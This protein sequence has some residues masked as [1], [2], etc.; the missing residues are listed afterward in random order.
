MN[1]R[2]FFRKH[3][4]KVF[5]AFI[6]LQLGIFALFQNLNHS[7]EA[8]PDSLDL[9]EGRSAKVSPL[10]NDLD[11]NEKDILS[12]AAVSKPF[13]GTAIQ[14]G[15]VI[16]YTP[17]KGFT[18]K[19]SLTYTA[20]DGKKESRPAVITFQVLKNQAPIAMNDNTLLYNGGS[21]IIYALDNDTDPEKDSLTIGEITK[22]LYGKAEVSGNTIIYSI[23]N[24]AVTADSF[25]YTVTDGKNYSAK[26]AVK[27]NIRKRSDICYPWLSA[28]I[29][30]VSKPGKIL[31]RNN[32]MEIEASGSDI[33]NNTDGFS[34]IFQ[35][36]T[37]DFE[38]SALVESL[39]GSHEWAK[40]GLMIRENLGA[41]SKNAFMG[42]TTQNGITTQARLQ[43]R[44]IT[45]N[46]ERKSEVKAPYWLKLSRKGD[47]FQLAVSPDGEKWEELRDAPIPMSNNVLVGFAVTSHD[48][49]TT[50]KTVVSHYNL[51]QL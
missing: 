13:H 39:E 5:I 42:L 21:T 50:C 24:P 37:G 45:E 11:K 6:A 17:Q 34:F 44:E 1:V 27:I 10:L 22:P 49:T 25:Y 2:E 51:K 19:D 7:P 26:A 36:I 18:G 31:C 20:S 35:M 4:M 43:S 14:K 48:N 46:G 3:L 40:S 29:G 30:D 23:A 32:S 41:A 38:I 8:V 15:N 16:I 47:T 33:W 12:L 9:I 28:D